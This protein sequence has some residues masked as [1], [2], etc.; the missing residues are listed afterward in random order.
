MTIVNGYAMN[1]KLKYTLF[2]SGLAIVCGYIA[3]GFYIMEIE[4]HYGDLHPLFFDSKSG[5]VIINETYSDVGIIDKGWKRITVETQEGEVDL[6]N[7]A[8]RNGKQTEVEV[9]RPKNKKTN[10]KGLTFKELKESISDSELK[11]VVKSKIPD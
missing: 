7:F 8:Y 11:F 3:F 5:D 10:W 4:D 9:Y 1:K 2:F 6:F